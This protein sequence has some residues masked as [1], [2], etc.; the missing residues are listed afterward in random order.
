MT[1]DPIKAAIAPYMLA[2]KLGGAVVLLVS[3]SWCSYDAGRD[4]WKGKYTD[5]V[6]SHKA[7][8][9][10]LADLT[11]AAEEKAK[12][13]NLA[14]KAE[15]KTND[16]RFKDAEHEA[17]KAKRDLAAAL[18]RGDVRLRDEWTC[19]ATGPAEGGTSAAP[20]RQDASADLR[21]TGAANL[22]AAAD[23]AD[24]WINWLQAEVISTRQACGV[25]P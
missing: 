16:Q 3:L 11:K 6:A 7:V 21:A 9:S 17:D 1:L 20:R 13:A 14:A 12:K 2:I 10:N 15:R 23:H 24:N 8:I 5:A 22:I 18:R 4:K 19:P 25:T